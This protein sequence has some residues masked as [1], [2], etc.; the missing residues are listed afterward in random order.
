MEFL[1]RKCGYCVMYVAI[2]S[3]KDDVAVG[4]SVLL[5]I[6]YLSSVASFCVDYACADFERVQSCISHLCFFSVLKEVNVF[7]W[8]RIFF[9]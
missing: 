9:V 8:A 2:S 3:T 4:E 7:T 6:A 5:E 1:F